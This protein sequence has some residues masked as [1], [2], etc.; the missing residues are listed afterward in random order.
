M[1]LNQTSKWMLMMEH[2]IIDPGDHPVLVIRF[3]DLK[4]DAVTEIKKMLDFLEFP[5]SEVKLEERLREGYAQFLRGHDD[6]FEH[7]TKEQTAHVN[8]AIRRIIKRLREN[9]VMD[10]IGLPLYLRT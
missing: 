3:E 5:Y 7:Y 6:H 1:V 2:Y 10:S 9:D 4:R 8:E